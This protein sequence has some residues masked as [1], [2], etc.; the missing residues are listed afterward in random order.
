V[1][2][3]AVTPFPEFAAC[4]ISLHVTS[5][6]GD[7]SAIFISRLPFYDSFVKLSTPTNN[8]VPYGDAGEETV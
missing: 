6:D 1:T 3:L 5:A 7:A 8:L 4:P 2:F